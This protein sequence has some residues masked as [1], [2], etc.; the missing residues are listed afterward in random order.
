MQTE[1][2]TALIE[3]EISAGIDKFLKKH[4]FTTDYQCQ[5][6]CGLNAGNVGMI[7]KNGGLTVKTLFKLGHGV[8][9]K[10]NWFQVAAKVLK[11]FGYES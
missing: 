3:V 8:G 1:Y 2:N 11:D 5:K 7:R 10:G 4:G 9:Y 6:A